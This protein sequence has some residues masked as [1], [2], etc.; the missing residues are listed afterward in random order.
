V[1]ADSLDTTSATTVFGFPV[2]PSGWTGTA[3]GATAEAYSW[4]A[5]EPVPPTGVQTV[6]A[7]DEAGLESASTFTLTADSTPPSGG[8]INYTDGDSSG[9]TVNVAFDAGTDALAGIDSS[10]GV[11]ESATAPLTEEA[12]GTFSALAIVATDPVSGASYPVAGGTCYAYRYSVADNVGNRT[13]YV[14]ASVT[15]SE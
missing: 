2:L 9:P 11:L 15:L 6:T 5:P 1:T 12:C 14:S 8:G 10:S 7:T 4:S 3:A 13:T